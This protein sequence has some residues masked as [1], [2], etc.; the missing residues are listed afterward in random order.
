MSRNCAA[1]EKKRF[2]RWI[3]KIIE[4]NLC[5]FETNQCLKK[6]KSAYDTQEHLF[7]Q[8]RGRYLAFKDGR[9]LPLTF[10]SPTDITDLKLTEYYG[11]VLIFI[12]DDTRICD[13][14]QILGRTSLS[15]DVMQRKI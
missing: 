14:A 15:F 4:S 10:G 3:D 12:P 13:S 2:L 6:L 7:R 8:F 11:S 9:L 5:D 1:E